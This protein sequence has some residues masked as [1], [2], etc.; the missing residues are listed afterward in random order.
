MAERDGGEIALSGETANRLAKRL[1]GREAA[2][3]S[4]VPARRKPRDRRPPRAGCLAKQCN[5]GT[6]AVAL[7]MC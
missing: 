5:L 4:L 7:G 3:L 6:A 2:R 1:A